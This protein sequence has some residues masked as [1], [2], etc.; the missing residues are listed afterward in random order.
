MNLRRRDLLTLLGGVAAGWPIAVR[1]QQAAPVVGVL[2]PGVPESFASRVDGFRKGLGE[3]GFVEGRNVTIEYRWARGDNAALPELAADLVR[4]K[5][6]VIATPGGGVVAIQA[7]QAATATIPIVFS[8]GGDPVELGLVPSLSRPG[9]NVTGFNDMNSLLGAKRLGLLHELLPEAKKFA[10]LVNPS[11]PDASAMT[12][13]VQ[14][15]AAALGRNLEIVQASSNQEI[16]AAFA[17]LAQKQVEAL[18]LTT[19]ALFNNRRAQIIALAAYHRVPAIYPWREAA[20]PGGLMFYGSS[21][22]DEYRQV[23][24]YVGR[25]LKGEKPADLPVMRASKF[26]LII[27]LLTAKL[28]GLQFPPSLLAIA[29]EVIE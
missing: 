18:V 24:I 11:R 8:V 17:S 21:G 28:L 9:G 14:A 27:N 3:A 25:I 7:A 12:A 4:R 5:V 10:L 1:A 22:T 23:G 6:T 15:A 16:E 2:N 13:D 20:E 29:D 19:D 26:E